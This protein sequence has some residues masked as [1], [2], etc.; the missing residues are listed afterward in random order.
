MFTIC[1]G[2]GVATLLA[3]PFA[4]GAVS[5]GSPQPSPSPVPVIS[6]TPSPG[7]PAPP[8]SSTRFDA[9]CVSLVKVAGSTFLRNLCTAD[10]GV[11]V[12]CLGAGGAGGYQTWAFAVP[13]WN[14]TVA[15]KPLESNNFVTVSPRGVCGAETDA[16]PTIIVAAWPL[17]PGGRVPAQWPRIPGPVQ[18]FGN[19]NPSVPSSSILVNIADKPAVWSFLCSNAPDQG[20]FIKVGAW[21]APSTIPPGGVAMDENISDASQV[22][23]SSGGQIV[24]V[25]SGTM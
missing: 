10:A 13:A 12:A 23:C 1:K 22:H 20:G 6:P 4:A 15:S 8:S 25:A 14:G 18:P 5:L 7:P 3:L 17:G 24:V 19:A 9:D 16:N 21:T 2:K 11:Q